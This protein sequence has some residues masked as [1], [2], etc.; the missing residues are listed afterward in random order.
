MF[1]FEFDIKVIYLKD[2]IGAP[3][4]LDIETPK[5]DFTRFVSDKE[6]AIKDT[7][8]DDEL[9]RRLLAASLGSDGR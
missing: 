3:G 6:N 2:Y 9:A 7:V 1:Y 8:N 4:R 5:I